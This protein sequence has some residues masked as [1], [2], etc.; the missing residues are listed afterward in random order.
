MVVL[1]AIH[2]QLYHNMSY[3]IWLKKLYHST[4]MRV[5]SCPQ[6]FTNNFS[7]TIM[8]TFSK[9]I[10]LQC[11]TL[12]TSVIWE[13]TWEW[14]SICVTDMQ[15]IFDCNNNYYIYMCVCTLQLTDLKQLQSHGWNK[16][17][18]LEIASHG[19]KLR[20]R[21]TFSASHGRK[22]RARSKL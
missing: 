21:S 18:E 2:I 16:W 12:A 20:V 17:I 10:N 7:M 8:T 22:L 3:R 13:T 6:A 5:L 9:W 19:R 4:L 1:T 15:T 14:F 11:R